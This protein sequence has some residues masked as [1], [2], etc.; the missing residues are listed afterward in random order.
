MLHTWLTQAESQ[1]TCLFSIFR[2]PW[3]CL[4]YLQKQSYM[5]HSFTVNLDWLCCLKTRRLLSRPRSMVCVSQACRVNI[6]ISEGWM[7]GM[8]LL[9]GENC[10]YCM[11]LG[12]SIFMCVQFR[13]TVHSVQACRSQ[14]QITPDVCMKG[15]CLT[16]PCYNL[17]LWCS[18]CFFPSAVCLW[19]SV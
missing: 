8:L 11:C 9:V 6:Y 17:D 14:T 13:E 2:N 18:V 10:I 16:L 19:V 4:W 7:W 15:A 5:F 12:V 3:L 1:D